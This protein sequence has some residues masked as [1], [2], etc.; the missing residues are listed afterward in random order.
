MLTSMGK[1][2]GPVQRSPSNNDI[3]TSSN[4]AC[5]RFACPSVNRS[6]HAKLA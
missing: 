2:H 6:K 5:M 1:S 4:T 3:L